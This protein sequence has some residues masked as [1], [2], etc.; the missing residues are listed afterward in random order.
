MIITDIT[1]IGDPQILLRNETYY[2]Y[3]TSHGRGFCVWTSRD[4]YSFS[5]PQLCFFADDSHWADRDFWAP[6]VVYHEGR[7]VMHYSARMKRSGSLRIG[8]AVSDSPLGPFVDVQNAPM[9][10]LGYATIDGSVFKYNGENYFYYSRDC[11]E[12]VIDGVHTSQLY[13]VRLDETLTHTVGGHV[14]VTTP[15][16]GWE[17]LSLPGNFIWNEGPALIERNGK[18]IM[19]YS[20]NSYA[21]NDYSICIATADSPMGPFTKSEKANPVLR[22]RENLFGA[23]HNAFF[24]DASGELMTSFHVQTNSE[25]PSGNRRV[26]IGKVSFTERDGVLYESIY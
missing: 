26:C 10:D 14:L 15:T 17:L 21:S 16:Y 13:C 22:S 9:F 3:A 12:N 24:R 20:A 1:G 5:E 7:F 25:K 11:S 8:V 23:G 6:E 4:L 18:I 2:C 19:N